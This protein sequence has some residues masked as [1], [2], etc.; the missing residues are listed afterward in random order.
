MPQRSARLLPTQDGMARGGRRPA[1]RRH[2]GQFRREERGVHGPQ[3][4]DRRGFGCRNRAA[5][6]P[7]RD[8]EQTSSQ[9]P[10]GRA[11]SAVGKAFDEYLPARGA[12]FRPLADLVFVAGQ[13]WL[14]V[15]AHLVEPESNCHRFRGARGPQGSADLNLSRARSSSAWGR[16]R[17]FSRRLVAF[18]SGTSGRRMSSADRPRGGETRRGCRCCS[19]SA[20]TRA[21]SA[22]LARLGTSRP[23]G[24]VGGE[25][26]SAEPA[27]RPR[28]RRRSTARAKPRGCLVPSA[29][30]WAHDHVRF[31]AHLS[32]AA[33][34][35][36]GRTPRDAAHRSG[37]SGD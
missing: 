34:E 7:P 17:R 8:L 27:G 4:S 23:S 2:N 16:R 10:R 1:R 21:V 26:Q 11:R 32:A 15:E 3:G 5:A 24:S 37:R 30:E 28:R 19:V 22:R 9:K 20:V 14:M 31:T 18:F 12:E 13:T 29:R 6:W 33:R 36:V 35:R 25:R